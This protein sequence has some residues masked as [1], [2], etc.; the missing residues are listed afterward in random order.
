[1]EVLSSCAADANKL[2][3]LLGPHTAAAVEDPCRPNAQIVARPAHEGG[4]A[5]GGQ[6]DGVALRGLYSREDADQLRRLS[7][8]LRKRRLR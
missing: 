4:V 1:M 5:V 6:R 3:A 7:R 2:G 8:E